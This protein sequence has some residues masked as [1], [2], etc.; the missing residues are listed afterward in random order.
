MKITKRQLKRIIKEE[1]VNLS[2]ELDMVSNHKDIPL[3]CDTP[4]EVEANEDS[5]AGG[6]NV[7]NQIDHAK[8]AGAEDT[9]Q[10][11]EILTLTESQ[12][13]KILRSILLEE[14]EASDIV[15]ARR[16]DYK[17]EEEQEINPYGTGNYEAESSDQDEPGLWHS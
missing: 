2:Y 4:E 14:S 8:A 12:L 10:G 13:R 7:Q 17:D 16:M 3:A 11:I 9:T 15:G 6:N 5:W 1:V